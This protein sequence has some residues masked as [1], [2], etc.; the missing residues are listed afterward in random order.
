M[1]VSS[2]RTFLTGHFSSHFH[3]KC[4]TASTSELPKHA[5]HGTLF[6][7]TRTSTTSSSTRTASTTTTTTMASTRTSRQA[8]TA[9]SPGLRR[10]RAHSS[11]QSAWLEDL[12]AMS[13]AGGISNQQAGGYGLLAWSSLRKW[14][15]VGARAASAAAALGGRYQLLSL[16]SSARV[17]AHRHRTR[18]LLQ[19]TAHPHTRTHHNAQHNYVLQ[20]H[21]TGTTKQNR[22][23]GHMEK[24]PFFQYK[25][26]DFS[27][28]G[29]DT[30]SNGKNPLL[31]SRH[32][33]SAPVLRS[34]RFSNRDS[35]DWRAWAES[36]R[37]HNSSETAR[38]QRG[39][40]FTKWL[41]CQFHKMATMPFWLK[42]PP[43]FFTHPLLPELLRR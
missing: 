18:R 37:E 23:N 5:P 27:K 34:V 3:K 22:K 7:A 25:N 36:L 40:N 14:C 41:P 16:A 43:H 10:G 13:P 38:T 28:R 26:A 6:R 8:A 32:A 1:P 35:L 31:S 39:G 42:L 4:S 30:A 11:L 21:Y 33:A 29:L 20:K 9:S 17:S 12:G 15:D 2:K 19:K 24:C